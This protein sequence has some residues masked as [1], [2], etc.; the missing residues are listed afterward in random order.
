VSW[1]LDKDYKS[2]DYGDVRMPD[3]PRLKVE[4][5]RD[6]PKG[7][8]RYAFRERAVPGQSLGCLIIREYHGLTLMRQDVAWFVDP[9]LLR[10]GSGTL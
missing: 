7:H 4:P 10:L 3:Q 5:M 8:W 2:M 9:E 6:L 1:K